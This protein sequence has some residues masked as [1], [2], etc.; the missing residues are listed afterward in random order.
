MPVPRD[1]FS[2]PPLPDSEYNSGMKIKATVL[3]L[4]VL[5]ASFTVQTAEVPEDRGAMGLSQALNRLDVIGSVLHT[6]AH[7]DDENSALL[8]WLARGQ[9]VRTAYLSATRGDGGQN[10]LGTEL[11]EALG[12]IRSEELVAARRADHAQQ[13]FTPVYEFGFSKSSDEA[14]EKWGHREML[15]DFVRVI[16]QFKPEIIVSRFRGTTQDGHG[17]HQ[18][19]GIITQEAFTAAADPAQFPEFGRPWQAK[20][21]YLSATGGGGAAPNAPA[22]PTIS[23]NTGEFNPALGRSYSEIAAE[24][25]SLHRSQGQGSVQNRGPSASSLQLVQKTVQAADD[26]PLFSGVLYK[27]TD[28]AAVEPSLAQDL[29]RLQQQVDSVRQKANLVR[30]QELVADLVSGLKQLQQIRTRATTDHARFLLEVKEDDFQEAIRLAAGL[31]LDVLASDDTIIP[32]QEFNV[33]VSVINGGTATY[34]LPRIGFD[35]PVGWEASVQVPQAGGAAGGRGG[36]R[37]APGAAGGRGGAAAVETTEVRPGQKYDQVYTVKVPQNAEFTQPYWLKQ[38]RTND[39]F[40]WPAGSPVNM[41]FDAPL[42]TARASID[43]DGVVIAMSHP[44]EYRFAD[45]MLGEQRTD[46]N[47]VPAVSVKL[48]PDVAVIPIRGNREKEFTVDL[49]NQGAAT[50]NA[51]VRLTVPQGWTLTPASQTVAFTRQ[52][53]KTSVQFKVTAPATAG[54]FDVRAVATVGTQEFRTGYTPVAYPHIETHNLYSPAQSRAEVF[55]VRTGISSVGY[56]EGVGDTVPQSLRQ[57]GMNVTMLTPQDL[58]SGDLS[59]FPTIILGI[60]AYYARDDVR[61]Y[62]KRLLDYVSGGGNLVVQY[63]RSEDVGNVQFG[64]FPFAIN[65]NDRITREEAPVKILQPAHALF[66]VPNQITQADF[67]GWVQ[68]RGTYFL[69]AWDPQYVPLLES[70]DPGEDPKQG[71]LVVAKYG[72]GT[73]IYTGYVF[74]RE[75]SAG[76]P[77]AYRLFANLVSLED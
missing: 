4:L 33:T 16:R 20:K 52:G 45:R 5:A 8:S 60:R 54:S 67:D 30:P 42:V 2:L 31:V 19:A 21:L 72:K 55:D 70:S 32:G 49:E 35:L 69:R 15:G 68:E 76:V 9:G 23:V 12:V 14:F 57:L 51:E 44:A 41:P 62:N 3:V 10:L 73:Y 37:G 7:P 50:T 38:P 39:R 43:Y 11:F 59:R 61:A 22:P 6:G 48:S 25:R 56:V 75:L 47:V 66:N 65:N 24:G 28:L 63:N 74:F 29:N 36:G 64:P 18:A 53:E 27:L 13:F 58:A 71:G 77:G 26:A 1:S 40:V 34:P 46:I 17:H